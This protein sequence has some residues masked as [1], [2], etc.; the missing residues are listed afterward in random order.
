[1]VILS[2]NIVG[3]STYNEIPMSYP[4][5]N[6]KESL[7]FIREQAFNILCWSHN[8]WGIPSNCKVGIKIIEINSIE[9]E[10]WEWEFLLACKNIREFKPYIN[11]SREDF[12]SLKLQ[13]ERENS[14]DSILE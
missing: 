1:M 12:S 4:F 7:N 3:S 14:I 6:I 8:S 5:E 13:K 2:L 11:L 9:E 10:Y